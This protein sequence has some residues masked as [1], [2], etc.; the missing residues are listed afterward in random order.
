V[1]KLSLPPGTRDFFTQEVRSRNRLIQII[2]NNFELFGFS[3]IETPSFENLST[4][5]GKYGGESDQLIFKIINSGDFLKK[6]KYKFEHLSQLGLESGQKFIE[7]QL[8]FRSFIVEISEKALRYDLTIPLSRYVAMHRDKI[9]FPF[10]RYQIQNVWRGDRPQKDRFREFCQCDADII[11]S[12]SLWQEIEL[13]QLYDKIFSDMN[14]PVIIKINHRE[15][16]S[17]LADIAKIKDYWR[18]FIISLDKW[19]KIG[20]HNVWKE[21]IRRGIPKENLKKIQGVFNI[22]GN[23]EEKLNKLSAI[24]L[25]SS[26]ENG[27]KGIEELRFFLKI[28]KKVCLDWVDLQFQIS[29]VRGLNY[30]TGIIFEVNPKGIYLN[31]IGGGGRYDNLTGIFGL[32]NISGVGI[33]LGLDRIHIAKKMMNPKSEDHTPLR[34]LFLH[35]GE[36]ES[37]YA[38]RLISKLRKKVIPAELYPKAEKVKK[39]FQYAIKKKISFVISVGKKEIVKN[40]IRI[41]DMSK[42]TEVEYDCIEDFIKEITL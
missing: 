19:D 6:Q 33:S 5:F 39:Q 8:N 25:S 26:S 13:I 17:G 35:F 30:Y 29:L 31:S 12:K 15:I 4:L 32:P 20:S 3:P 23:F 42:T 34:V 21:M 10:K 41:K 38:N 9:H 40:K 7:E 27:K 14:L 2:R 36:E 16:I 24:I 11:G 28:I 1:K 22:D 18:D 37:L